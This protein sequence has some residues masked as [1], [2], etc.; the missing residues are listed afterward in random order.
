MEKKYRGKS[1]L[2]IVQNYIDGTR[3]FV[4][5]GYT[6]PEIK[7]ELGSTWTD[8]NGVKWEQRNGYKTRV[9]EQA[10]MIKETMKQKCTC[11][12]DI[13]F[14]D[15]M[16]QL[17]FSKTG[18]CFDCLIMEETEYRALGV[19]PLYESYKLLSNYLG[20]L[21]DMKGKI[22]DS[23]Q[24]FDGEDGTLKILCNSEGFIENFRGLN[25]T[26]LLVSAKKDLAEIIKSIAKVT[27]EKNKAKKAFESELKKKRKSL[28]PKKQNAG[29][30]TS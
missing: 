8:V 26:D 5:V 16:D 23:V 6:P 19:F 9:N 11:G 1:N 13:K 29:Q 4:Q 21:E 30:P 18:K 20:F 17:F 27:R 10:N 28:T 25:T 24:Y 2:E 12:Q 14:G 15:R 3:P 22:E 7:R